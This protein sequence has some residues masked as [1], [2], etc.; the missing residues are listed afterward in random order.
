MEGILLFKVNNLIF[1]HLSGFVRKILSQEIFQRS[2][3]LPI[4]P[5]GFTLVELLVVIAI[6]GVLASV[7]LASVN[8]ARSKARNARERSDVRQIVFALEL[9]R[10]NSP[11][12]KYPSSASNG[13][14]FSCFKASGTCWGTPSNYT[15]LPGQ[16]VTDLAPY[17]PTFPLTAVNAP[18]DCFAYDSHLYISHQTANPI[19][20]FVPPTSGPNAYLIWAKEGPAFTPGECIGYAQD[21]DCG[22][23]YCY[24]YIGPN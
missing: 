20:T 5:R 17:L 10:N 18:S 1:K 24:Q 21:V 16:A 13:T 22:L 3:V 12:D 11:E 19:G 6:I 4:T 15:A 2:R 8:S 7:V 9:A 23:H 14:D